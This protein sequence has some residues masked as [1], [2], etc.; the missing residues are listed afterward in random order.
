MWGIKLKLCRIVLNISFYKNIVFL[1]PLLKCFGCYG[2]LNFW[3]TMGDLL[4]QATPAMSTSCISILSL[5]SKWFFNPNIFT[6]YIFAFQLRLCR[7]WLT[8][9]NGYLEVLFHAL[10]VFSITFAAAMSKPKIGSRKSAVLSASAM[11]FYYLRCENL[12]NNGQKQLLKWYN[13]FRL[14]N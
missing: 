13:F 7:K 1:L 9:S 2:N 8:W 4:L 5:M 14:T 6:L 11:Y 10:D 12:P 3:L